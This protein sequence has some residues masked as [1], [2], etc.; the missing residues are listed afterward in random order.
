ME[1]PSLSKNRGQFERCG[2]TGQDG[3]YIFM[4]AVSSEL[5]IYMGELEKLKFGKQKADR[6]PETGF[7][8]RQRRQQREG[9]A[10]PPTPSL[11]RT[12]SGKRMAQCG[13][14]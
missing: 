8:R 7:Y 11:W 9:Q 14:C 6:G 5:G 12:G 2:E 1:I 13:K 4:R 3:S 10:H